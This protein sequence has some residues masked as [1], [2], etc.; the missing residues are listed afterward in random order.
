MIQIL[1]VDDNQNT[2]KLMSVVLQK[3]NYKISEVTNGE[4]ALSF[5]QNN[6]VSLIILD[7]MMP[8]MNGYQLIQEIRNANN[9]VPI[10]MVSAKDKPDDRIKGFRLGT[11]DYLVKPFNEQEFVLRIK[12]L[13]KR[14]TTEAENELTIGSTTLYIDSLTVKNDV[15]SIIMPKKEFQ[16]LQKFLTYPN[17]TFTRQQLMEEFWDTDSDSMEHTVDVH[18]S[19]IR[20]KL[21]NI[22]DFEIVTVR[23]LGYKALII[24]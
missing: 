3:Q 22:T 4:E 18:V 23:G 6:V 7:I 19:R 21:K 24:K 13:L 9:N 1:I 12:A 14:S 2:R 16:L 17:K 8:K 15:E 20:D 11:D 10:L 5:L